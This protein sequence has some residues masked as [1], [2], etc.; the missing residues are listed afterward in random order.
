MD[1]DENMAKACPELVKILE[2]MAIAEEAGDEFKGR[3]WDA[4]TV[5]HTGGDI[6]LRKPADIDRE[7]FLE[8][9]KE[10]SPVKFML[11]EP[12]FCEMLWSEHVGPKALMLTITKDE[13]YIGYC[14]INNTAEDPWEIGI[15]ILPQWTGKGIGYIAISGMLEAIKA[16]LGITEFL[17]RIRPDNIASQR[18]FKRL[19]AELREPVGQVLEFS[20]RW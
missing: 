11:K 15:E 12:A 7:G 6:F 8:S 9:Q 18:L 4:G 19:G 3:F 1:W 2:K 20:L 10:Y 16:R 14:G 5:I 13:K 17:V